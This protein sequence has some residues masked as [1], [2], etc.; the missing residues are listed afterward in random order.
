MDSS[1]QHTTCDTKKSK[2]QPNGITQNL[3]VVAWG[4]SFIL[5]CSSFNYIYN[6]DVKIP[7]KI[8]DNML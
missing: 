6:L 4:Q 7:A 3:L 2:N 1:F 8:I 5:V